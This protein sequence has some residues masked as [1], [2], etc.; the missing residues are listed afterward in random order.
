MMEAKKENRILNMWETIKTPSKFFDFSW[1]S[2]KGILK[3]Q[4]LKK[5]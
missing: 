1:K 2:K 3:W 5:K 4:N